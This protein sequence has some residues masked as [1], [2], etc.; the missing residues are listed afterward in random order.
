MGEIERNRAIRLMI[1]RN[2][3]LLKK[4]DQEHKANDEERLSVLKDA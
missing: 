4:L 2:H 3:A 1:K